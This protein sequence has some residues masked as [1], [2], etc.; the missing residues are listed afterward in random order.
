MLVSLIVSSEQ[1][2]SK[3]RKAAEKSCSESFYVTEVVCDNC[4]KPIVMTILKGTLVEEMATKASCPN[5]ACALWVVGED[6]D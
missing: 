6:D 1:K 2:K 5:C 3:E 4:S